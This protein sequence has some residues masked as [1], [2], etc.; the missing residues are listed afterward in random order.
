MI[1]E[2]TNRRCS[3]KHV[4]SAIHCP[5]PTYKNEKKDDMCFLNSVQKIRTP[6]LKF[7]EKKLY[8]WILKLNREYIKS[9]KLMQLR[10]KGLK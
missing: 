1:H 2:D 10:S 3:Q 9:S 4:D 6:P 8:L 5:N 7:F